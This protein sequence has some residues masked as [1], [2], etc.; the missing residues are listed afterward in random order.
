VLKAVGLTAV[1]EVFVNLY[2]FPLPI[3]LLLLPTLALLAAMSVV[4]GTEDRFAVVR[5]LVDR[6]PVSLTISLICRHIARI[7]TGGNSQLRLAMQKVEG[8]SSF[9]RSS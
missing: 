5:K 9:S 2:V 1:V 3:E 7:A 6:Q 4:A 8:S